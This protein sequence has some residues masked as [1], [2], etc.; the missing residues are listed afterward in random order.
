ML[1]LKVE[2]EEVNMHGKWV[3]ISLGEDFKCQVFVFCS[4]DTLESDLQERAKQKLIKELG[5]P[6]KG[7]LE[8]SDSLRIIEGYK[9]ERR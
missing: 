2:K 9:K 1:L 4:P 8:L 7:I 5:E 6:K 3:D